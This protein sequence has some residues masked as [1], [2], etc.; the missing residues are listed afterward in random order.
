[1]YIIIIITIILDYLLSYFIP[2]Y[3]N[4]LTLFYPMLTLTLVIFLHNK[5][6]NYLKTIFIIGFIY[7]LLFSYIFFFNSLIFLLFG[8]LVKKIDKLIRTNYLVNI[9]LVIVCIFLYDLIL[10]MLVKL[11]NYNVVT[12]S[13]LVYKFKNSIILNVLYFSLLSI[14]KIPNK[15]KN[16]YVIKGGVRNLSN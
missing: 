9:L 1:M 5:T 7:D 11:S 15:K 8:K 2:S 13:D 12:L 14:I 10:F 16:K 6:S 4:N 3:F